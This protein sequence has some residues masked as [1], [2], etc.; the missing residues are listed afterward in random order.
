MNL[1]LTPFLLKHYTQKPREINRFNVSQIW[2]I[3]NNYTSVKEFLEG[4]PNNFI[5]CFRMWEGTSKHKQ[6]QMLFEGLEEYQIE[7]KIEFKPPKY[8]WIL[9]G[10]ADLL[11]KDSVI[12]IKTSAD[13]MP[14]AKP[15]AEYQTRIYLSLFK[16]P[17]GLI[18]QPII[19]GNGIFLKEIGAVKKNDKW[20]I[21]QLKLLNDFH[22]KLKIGR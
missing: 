7:K 15:W 20:F 3:V 18:C 16:R 19:K 5:S 11:T 6:I 8:D 4:K 13:L 10:K 22:N 1:D 12:E 2:G 9:V 14:K 21:E 17:T